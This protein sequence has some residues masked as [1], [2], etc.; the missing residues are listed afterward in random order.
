[1]FFATK[2]SNTT[3]ILFTKSQD[4]TCVDSTQKKSQFYNTKL[5][6]LLCMLISTVKRKHHFNM[7]SYLGNGKYN[8]NKNLTLKPL[9][10]YFEL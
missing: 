5:I 4:T 9:N 7:L 1:M 3:S 6:S 8:T 2:A 10:L